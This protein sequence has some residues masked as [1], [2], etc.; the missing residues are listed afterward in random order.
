M[1]KLIFIVISI[2]TSTQALGTVFI[3]KKSI[4]L[5]KAWESPKT[6]WK[7]KLQIIYHDLKQ[8]WPW[9]PFWDYLEFIP[10]HDKSSLKERALD[11]IYD[12]KIGSLALPVFGAAVSAMLYDIYKKETKERE[13][14]RGLAM[15]KIV[16]TMLFFNL[17]WSDIFERG[18]PKNDA[19]DIIEKAYHDAL[20]RHHPDKTGAFQSTTLPQEIKEKRNNLLRWIQSQRDMYPSQARESSIEPQEPLRLTN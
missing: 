8:P 16:Q 13:R 15:I 17:T 20:R 2:V 11:R 19:E 12:N 6:S 7:T 18:T 4:Q 3:S 14:E 9:K 1:K 10:N 5:Q